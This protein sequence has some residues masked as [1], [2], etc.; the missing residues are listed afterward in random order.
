MEN[1]GIKKAPATGEDWTA[2]ISTSESLSLFIQEVP[3]KSEK[4]H[5]INWD[6]VMKKHWG[7]NPL[8]LTLC[9]KWLKPETIAESTKALG[10]FF[11]PKEASNKAQHN[12]LISIYQLECSEGEVA[13]EAHSVN[14]KLPNHQHPTLVLMTKLLPNHLGCI[15]VT[16]P[17]NSVLET[18]YWTHVVNSNSKYISLISFTNPP[19]KKTLAHW[20]IYLF[21]KVQLPLF[22]L[23]GLSKDSAS[24]SGWAETPKSAGWT[25]TWNVVETL[26]GRV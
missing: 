4:K 1:K 23:N 13:A 8:T 20:L 10:I 6:T 24:E 18:S 14:W 22:P 2:T 17:I 9:W 21:L 3:Q 19:P 11:S 5:A 25:S 16:K 15:E 7:F 12:H 26:G